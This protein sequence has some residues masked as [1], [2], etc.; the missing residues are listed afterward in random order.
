[1]FEGTFRENLTLWDN[2][3]TDS[4]SDRRRPR[5]P[6]STITSLRGRAGYGARLEEGGRN[7]SGGQRQRSRSPAD[8]KPRSSFWMRQRA[9]SSRD[10]KDR[11]RQHPPARLH[12]LSSWPIGS[13]PFAT[14]TRSSASSH[15]RIIER[16]THDVLIAQEGGFY[17]RLVSQ[18]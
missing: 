8:C 2:T 14:A 4:R 17:G 12:L 15:G 6:A 3:I 18:L 11:R 7:I 1:M 13:P 10:R 5:T 9:P 16:G